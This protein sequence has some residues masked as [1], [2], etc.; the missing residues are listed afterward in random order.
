MN[1]TFQQCSPLSVVNEIHV[2]HRGVSYTSRYLPGRL[3]TC[4]WKQVEQDGQTG[5]P[6]AQRLETW[7]PA[8]RL[9]TKISYIRTMDSWSSPPVLTPVTERLEPSMYNR[10]GMV[11]SPPLLARMKATRHSLLRRPSLIAVDVKYIF[12][13]ISY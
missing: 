9:G 11:Q 8:R 4:Q 7:V 2:G 3:G 13:F 1:P 6:E 10:N 5:K 12:K